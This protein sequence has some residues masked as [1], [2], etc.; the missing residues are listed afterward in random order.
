MI[1]LMLEC[2]FEEFLSNGNGRGSNPSAN[3]V[4][5]VDVETKEQED[6][7]CFLT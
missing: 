7:V 1:V 5:T 6:L 3:L 2:R 4:G